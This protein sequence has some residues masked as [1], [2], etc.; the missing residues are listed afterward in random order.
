MLRRSF[1][2]SFYSASPFSTSSPGKNSS[3]SGNVATS[4]AG[5]PNGLNGFTKRLGCLA[6]G[7]LL[8]DVIFQVLLQHLVKK[9]NLQLNSA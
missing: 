5:L 2:N 7:L 1:S 6:D 8:P 9:F 3:S 4:G